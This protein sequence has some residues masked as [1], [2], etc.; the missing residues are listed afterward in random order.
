MIEPAP[1]ARSIL[2]GSDPAVTG[3]AFDREDRLWARDNGNGRYVAV[4]VDGRVA[5]P[6]ATVR[7]RHGDVN[8]WAPTTFD[9]MAG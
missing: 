8:R 3:I 9:G 7:R 4:E 2:W 6:V 5:T 1:C